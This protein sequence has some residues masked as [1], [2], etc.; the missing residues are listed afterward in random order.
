[1]SETMYCPWCDE[2]VIA[3]AGHDGPPFCPL[4]EELLPQK[5]WEKTNRS[6][7][8]LDAERSLPSDT[9]Q[10]PYQV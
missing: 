9:A 1:M 6:A 3:V 8:I 10:D 4:C 5:D 7:P 2:H